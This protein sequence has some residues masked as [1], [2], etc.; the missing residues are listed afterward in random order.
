MSVCFS[1]QS[2]HK[3]PAAKYVNLLKSV[4]NNN[5]LSSIW[6]NI[7]ILGLFFCCTLHV[8]FNYK[9]HF[10]ALLI[11]KNQAYHNLSCHYVKWSLIFYFKQR[12]DVNS[13]YTYQH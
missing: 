13:V 7:E 12:K 10:S 8:A 11:I 3:V 5:N 9:G 2:G 1:V 6:Y 4:I